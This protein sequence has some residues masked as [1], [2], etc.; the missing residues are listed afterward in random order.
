MST[1][2]S[3][4]A[5]CRPNTVLAVAYDLKVFFTVVAKPP[6]RVR[7]V[8]G[9]GGQGV[10]ELVG[11]VQIQKVMRGLAPF[12]RVAGAAYAVLGLLRLRLR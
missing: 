7:P 9:L 12:A 10:A 6:P 5:G 3:W 8:D 11:V 1:W 2:S 4:L